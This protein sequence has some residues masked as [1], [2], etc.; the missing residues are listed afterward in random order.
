[1][2]DD[3]VYFERE[4]G[5][6]QTKHIQLNTR[7]HPQFSDTEPCFPGCAIRVSLPAQQNGKKKERRTERTGRAR[8]KGGEG[9][10]PVVGETQQ[11]EAYWHP[12]AL[13]LLSAGLVTC[14][15]VFRDTSVLFSQAAKEGQ[16]D[17]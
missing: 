4:S 15:S 17:G 7:K 1:M 3:L 13:P 5:L 11:R 6:K 8:M 10:G 9:G 14:H 16:G 12:P 2:P